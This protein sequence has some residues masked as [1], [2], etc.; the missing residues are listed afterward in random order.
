MGCGSSTDTKEIKIRVKEVSEVSGK[1]GNTKPEEVLYLI[2][3]ETFAALINIQD[4]KHVI[5][6]SIT[7]HNI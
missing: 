1:Q 6:L 4:L 5:H 7:L 2:I 3:R